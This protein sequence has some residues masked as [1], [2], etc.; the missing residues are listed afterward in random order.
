MPYQRQ[1]RWCPYALGVEF[2]VGFSV[3]PLLCFPIPYQ[4]ISTVAYHLMNLVGIAIDAATAADINRL[5]FRKDF[6]ELSVI[7]SAWH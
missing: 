1:N 3:C 7:C 5:A 2:E 4:L 6:G